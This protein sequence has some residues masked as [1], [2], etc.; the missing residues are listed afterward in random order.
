ML[1]PW[2]VSINIIRDDHMGLQPFL[3]TARPWSGAQPR[4]GMIPPRKMSWRGPLGVT[5]V[6]PNKWPRKWRNNW[7]NLNIFRDSIS[8]M[9]I[10]YDLYVIYYLIV[11]IEACL[12]PS[13]NSR[14]PLPQKDSVQRQRP[15]PRRMTR[16]RLSN[17]QTIKPSHSWPCQT[18]RFV[19]DFFI[20]CNKCWQPR[21]THIIHVI[22]ISK[23]PHLRSFRTHALKYRVIQGHLTKTSLKSGLILSTVFLHGLRKNLPSTPTP[24]PEVL[25]HLPHGVWSVVLT[26]R[27]LNISGVIWTIGSGATWPGAFQSF[28]RQCQAKSCILVQRPPDSSSPTSYH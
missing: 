3:W 17:H 26:G 2:R 7:N 15:D 22:G 4:T 8:F 25:P 24:A 27:H 11:W 14:G 9:M 18:L 12:L 23:S 6:P 5:F 28:C 16:Q 21:F 13:R 20:V 10:F 19:L 1:V